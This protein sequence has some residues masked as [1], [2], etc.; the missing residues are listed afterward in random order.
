[1][2]YRDEVR[3]FTK[4]GRWTFFK[5]LPLSLLIIITLGGI[6]FGLKSVGLIGS[7]IVEREVFEN[8]YQ[9]SEAL[10][11]Q[12]ALD[13]AVLTEIERKLM[14]PNLD[15]NTRYNLEAQASA[16]RIRIQTTRSK[17]Q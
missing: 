4:E 7:T 17:M 6:G 9:R 13:Q 10:K 15:E 11:S 12:M 14:N 2:T 3:E 16:T 1:M 5:V 8:S